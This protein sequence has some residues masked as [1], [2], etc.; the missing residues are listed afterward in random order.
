MT[1]QET[2]EAGWHLSEEAEVSS[3]GGGGGEHSGLTLALV[4]SEML[5]NQKTS[6]SPM[7]L[8]VAPG[9]HAF[10]LALRLDYCPPRV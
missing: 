5:R 3:L 6:V 8:G 7:Y 2:A 10:S 9:R 4:R 1:S